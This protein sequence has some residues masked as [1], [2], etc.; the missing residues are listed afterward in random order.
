[1]TI[2]KTSIG[3]EPYRTIWFCEG[4]TFV[5]YQGKW[6]MKSSSTGDGLPKRS[7]VMWGGNQ[8]DIPFGWALCNGQTYNDVTTPDLRG[9]FIF[10]FN[11]NDNGPLDSCGNIIKDVNGNPL[12][13]KLTNKMKGG[14]E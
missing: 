13:T 12:R 14:E 5:C 2:Q 11:P 4:V 10:G 1:M 7:I 8:N 9:R 6:I 3:Y